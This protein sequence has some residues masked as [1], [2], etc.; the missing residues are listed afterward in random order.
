MTLTEYFLNNSGDTLRFDV[1]SH[2][3]VDIQS[4]SL[5]HNGELGKWVWWF[6]KLSKEEARLQWKLY[7]TK[8]YR[9]E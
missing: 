8:G 6:Q 5:N 3:R 1:Y 2:G 4:R 9:H 7:K